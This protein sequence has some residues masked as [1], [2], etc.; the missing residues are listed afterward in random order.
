MH[1]EKATIRTDYA[2][3][4]LFLKEQQ[5]YQ[6]WLRLRHVGDKP[7]TWYSARHDTEKGKH[8]NTMEKFYILHNPSKQNQHLNDNHT[9]TNNPVLDIVI[10]QN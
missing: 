6:L 8:M 4:A 1:I 9:I 5:Q 3:T 2:N 7:Y 10:T